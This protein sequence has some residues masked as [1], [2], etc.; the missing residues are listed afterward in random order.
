MA[1]IRGVGENFLLGDDLD[2]VLELIREDL[3]S[4]SEDFDKELN[5]LPE[6]IDFVAPFFSKICDKVRQGYK[7]SGLELLI[8]C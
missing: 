8:E 5:A 4:E 6:E 2:A 3:P 1:S 7:I